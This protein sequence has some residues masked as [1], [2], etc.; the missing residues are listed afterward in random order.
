MTNLT[1]TPGWD[2]VPQLEK[3]TQALGGPGG[4]MNKQAQAL[5]N[6]IEFTRTD[7]IC[8]RNYVIT[9]EDDYTAAFQRAAQAA[10]DKGI[11]RVYL[12][13]N[14]TGYTVTLPEMQGIG[15]FGDGKARINGYLKHPGHIA[16]VI[17]GD[18]AVGQTELRVPRVFQLPQV[19]NDNK[20]IVN[21]ASNQNIWCVAMQ[22]EFKR[23][24]D[25]MMIMRRGNGG[26]NAP[27]DHIRSQ[28]IYYGQAFAKQGLATAIMGG[29]TWTDFSATPAQV[30]YPSGWEA[31]FAGYNTFTKSKTTTNAGAWIE[32]SVQSNKNG[33][34]R[35]T[36]LP[37]S[38][39]AAFS[40]AVNGSVVYN[41][42]TRLTVAGPRFRHVDVDIG[43]ADSAVVRVTHAGEEG[44]T[45]N[46]VGWNF[47]RPAETDERIQYD[48]FALYWDGNADY[49]AGVGAGDYAM[50]NDALGFFGS[51]H[52]SEVA[53][54]PPVWRIDG[55]AVGDTAFTVEKPY[56][57]KTI[58][59]L[60]KTRIANMIDATVYQ[61]WDG[62]SMHREVV[63]FDATNGIPFELKKLY[64]GMNGT[65]DA[66]SRVFLPFYA[67]GISG[68]SHPDLLLGMTNV[69]AQENPT[70]GQCV[71]THCN[72]DT[73]FASGKGGV[74]IKPTDET[75]SSYQKVYYAWIYDTPTMVTKVSGQIIKAFV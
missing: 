43:F 62:N 30:S 33:K 19:G 9:G 36:F 60:E 46:F 21:F 4:P 22:N 34:V 51:Y 55:V 48:S 67:E 40:V 68:A 57:G 72:I 32:R 65:Y 26:D 12:E 5:L 28:Q 14:G 69:V 63:T 7:K 42:T 70:T 24:K 50:S 71:Y 39:G 11:K 23:D 13:D 35:V 59:L 37:S 49:A 58:D 66:F 74:F 75:G 3:N 6:R 17:Y 10:K 41:G 44:Q 18:P 52:G 31:S 38:I 56:V 1:P 64:L 27:W 45:L 20:F 2:E 15:V 54:T 53:L 8:V 29:G 47:Q 25:V 61:R 16:D 73:G